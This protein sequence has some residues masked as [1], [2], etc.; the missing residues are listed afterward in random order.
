M[1]ATSVERRTS[2]QKITQKVSLPCLRPFGKSWLLLPLLWLSSAC[3]L[4][5]VG[6]TVK[7]DFGP[8]LS[9]GDVPRL[10]KLSTPELGELFSRFT[11]AEIRQLLRWGST[12]PPAKPG[13][14]TAKPGKVSTKPDAPPKISGSLDGFSSNGNRAR[15]RVKSGNVKYTFVMHRIRSRWLVHDI[16]IHRPGGQWSFQAILGLFITAK[17]ILGDARRGVTSEQR[18]TPALA[19]ALGPLVARLPAWGLLAKRDKEPDDE[20]GQ[21]PLLAFVDLAFSGD[22]AT[23]TFRVAGLPVDLM[24]RRSGKGWVLRDA[25]LRVPDRP[26][27]GL[28]AL[29]RALGP[30]LVVLGDMRYAPGRAP[31]AFEKVQALLDEKLAGQ[32]VPVLSPLWSPVVPLLAS[33]LRPKPIPAD[34]GGPGKPAVPGARALLAS[35]LSAVSW[36]ENG[37]DLETRLASGGWTLTTRWTTEGRLSKVSIW[38]GTQEIL[39]RHLAGFA[40]FSHWWNAVVSGQWSEPATWLH[41]GVRLLAA[42]LSSVEPLLPATLSLFPGPLPVSRLRPLLL[43]G[44]T[45][46]IG[47]PGPGTAP[48]TGDDVA[49]SGGK[50]PPVRLER[51]AFTPGQVV[52]EISTLGRR[53]HWS[54]IWENEVWRLQ[55]IRLDGSQDLLP[56]V[57]LLPPA[58]RALEGLSSRSADLFASSLSPDMQKKLGPGLRELFT[59]FGPWIETLLRETLEVLHLTLVEPPQWKEK[60]TDGVVPERPS[61]IALPKLPLLDTGKRTLRVEGRTIGFA[62]RPDGAWGLLLPD[63]PPVK[64]RTSIQDHALAIQELWPTLAGLYLGLATADPVALARFSSRD[65][66]RKVWRQVSGKQFGRLLE[67]LGVEVPL[68]TGRDIVGLL[69]PDRT[70][71]VPLSA[72]GT[73]GDMI[74]GVRR[75]SNLRPASVLPTLA[76]KAASTGRRPPSVRILGTLV[77]TD[78]RYPFA[79][80]WLLID[81]KRVDLNFSWDAKRSLFVL[82]EIRVQ[83]KVLGRD[84]TFGLKDHLKNFL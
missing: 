16:L 15:L 80:I 61:P 70:P 6:H 62:L 43:P 81:Q 17:D 52:L 82:D 26:A 35:V 41:E 5:S 74:D 25:V 19:A 44:T 29:A 33:R 8:A 60:P 83:M 39:P 75:L 9:T 65:F 72:T 59:T 47:D 23:A 50:H 20:S 7:K 84:M 11:D 18:M 2:V 69:L 63:P 56:Y 13:R 77:H 57:L 49:A 30:T 12:P 31:Y 37:A 78:R 22:D 32:L 76:R 36:K 71:A 53:W 73:V 28:L 1:D 3:T 42:P 10:V 45:S 24:A 66:T 55:S 67:R 46:A 68:L 21:E 64:E 40:P 58:W 51:F 34:K 27:L 4:V 38:T 48:S 54:W 14:A 79:E